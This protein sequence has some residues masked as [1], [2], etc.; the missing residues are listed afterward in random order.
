LNGG[1]PGGAAL[2]ES[3]F[4]AA[5]LSRAMHKTLTT[6]A[7]LLSLSAAGVP[8]AG[9]SKDTAQKPPTTFRSSLDLIAVDVQVIDREGVPVTGLSPD[10]FEVT[11][12]GRRRRVVSAD[13]VESRSA[14]VLT[15][16]ERAA[17]SGGPVIPMLPRVVVIAID[18]LSF[19]ASASRHILAAARDFIDRLPATDEV[20][21]F[22][23]PYGPKLNP[24]TDHSA[25]S[26]E[27]LNVIGQRDIPSHQFHL[28]PS[29]IVDLTAATVAGRTQEVS[30]L[31]TVARRECGTPVEEACRQRLMM[32]ILGTALYYEGQGNASLGMLRS[33]IEE[34]ANISGRKTLVLISAGMMASDVPG[35]RPDINELGMQV[36][37][38][39]ARANTSIYT[40]YL[41]TSTIDRFSAEVRSA[42]KNLQSE[43]RDSEVLGR[44]LD[45]FSGA[46]GGA[47]FKIQ[48]GSGELAFDRIYKEISAYYLLGVEPDAADRDGRTHEVKVRTTLKTATVRGRRWV[49]I[50]KRDSNS[51]EGAAESSPAEVPAAAPKASAPAKPRV[52]ANIQTLAD[53]YD[54]DVAAFQR[55][56]MQT[57]DLAALIRDF[58]ASDNPWPAAP[59]RTSVFALELGVAALRSDNRYA[60]DEGGRLLAEYNAR[61]RAPDQADA[62]ECSWLWTEVAALEGLFMADSAM[63]FV[64]HAVERCP[65]EARLHLANAIISEQQWLRGSTGATEEAEI[66][67]RYEQAIKFQETGAEARMRGAWFLSRTGK[68]EE[69]L[70]LVNGPQQPDSD[71]YV[72]YLTD[73]VRGQILRALNRPD[74]AEKAFRA[75]LTT[76]PDAQSAR[77]ALMTLQLSRGNRQEAAA[78]AEAAETAT[79]D[80]FD[81]WW[82]YWLG[83]YRV[84]PAIVAKLREMT[85]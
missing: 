34:L 77:V 24:T 6:L 69:A 81:P 14:M 42:D 17:A 1:V 5:P 72:H 51:S 44:W 25:V 66:L 82:T 78:L 19:D 63:L 20:A 12:N 80:Q 70:A 18:C 57:Q 74:E 45:Q 54:Q 46:A 41:D 30:V 35:G 56:L 7:M 64:P 22:A 9:Q 50:P 11:I 62:F 23:Y 71:R 47:M 40:L 75:A 3:V 32:E 4:W 79:S 59:K 21:L 2:F 53:L 83:D 60:R 48:V 29:E 68:L 84:Y 33:L 43:A 8:A 39:A 13:L 85:R 26:R 55:G 36:G 27:L 28:R 65:G 76:W 15:P 10:K 73:L 37:K 49:T 31:E 67:K 61:V 38:E 58:R 16:A 52:A